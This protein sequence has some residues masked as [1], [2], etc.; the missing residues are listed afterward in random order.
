[1]MI[2]KLALS[3]KRGGEIFE[4]IDTNHVFYRVNISFD[5]TTKEFTLRRK[6]PEDTRGQDSVS[7][8]KF[9]YD[10]LGNRLKALF[11]GIDSVALRI[12]IDELNENHQ[13]YKNI[14]PYVNV[15]L[16]TAILLYHTGEKSITKNFSGTSD[17]SFENPDFAAVSLIAGVGASYKR[18]NLEFKFEKGGSAGLPSYNKNIYFLLGYNFK[19]IEN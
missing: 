12:L 7:F 18:I 11:P 9:D 2:Q 1:M 17:V 5:D 10:I 3:I 15:G 16:S 4:V 19:S 8:T 6:E 14:K 13:K